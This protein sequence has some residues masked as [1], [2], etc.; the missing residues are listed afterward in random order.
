MVMGNIDVSLWMSVRLLASFRGVGDFGKN[1]EPT[2]STGQEPPHYVACA[3]CQ[4][5]SAL[6]SHKAQ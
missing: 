2:T 5:T 1:S 3:Q 6:Y 4:H